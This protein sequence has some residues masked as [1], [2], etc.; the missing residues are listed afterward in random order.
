[1]PTW[2]TGVN[3]SDNDCPLEVMMVLGKET[4]KRMTTFWE[5]IQEEIHP[6][7]VHDNPSQKTMT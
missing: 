4:R 2:S 6:T 3:G 7:W 5:T 1:M